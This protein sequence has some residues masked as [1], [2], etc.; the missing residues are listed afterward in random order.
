MFIDITES[1]V[2]FAYSLLNNPLT[3]DSKFNP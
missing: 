1:N 3:Q 2:D